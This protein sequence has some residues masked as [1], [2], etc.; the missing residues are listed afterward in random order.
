MLGSRNDERRVTHRDG[1]A[2]AYD[3]GGREGPPIVFL[4]PV[5][6]D[7]RFW[8]GVRERLGDRKT[9][10]V[11]FRGHGDSEAAS[12]PFSL[13]DLAMDVAAIVERELREP[14]VLVG[15]SMG[16]MVAQLVAIERSS[17]L[18]RLVLIDTAAGFDAGARRVFRERAE[19]V[20]SSGMRGLL[21]ETLDRWFTDEFRLADPDAVRT[22]AETLLADDPQTHAWAWEAIADLDTTGLTKIR[23]PTLVLV[24]TRD[25]STPSTA[26][27]QIADAIPNAEYDEIEG[28]AHMS[29]IELPDAVAMR[30]SPP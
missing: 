2:L 28:A 11:D 12:E 18:C 6:L 13:R 16:G 17:N 19:R 7:R 27:R 15:A 10:A 30:L 4:H 14:F 23:V 8:S 3:V 26:A 9:L 21:S 1:R 25:I 22:V 29:F 20:R 24:G 5:G